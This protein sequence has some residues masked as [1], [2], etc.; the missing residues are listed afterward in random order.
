MDAFAFLSLVIATAAILAWINHRFVGLP[1]TIGV[2]LVALLMSLGL[3]AGDLLGLGLTAP[4]EDLLERFDFG[5]SLLEIML[6]FLLFAGSLHVDL[7]LLRGQRWVIGLLATAGVVATTGLAGLAL[8]AVSNT[9][10]LGLSTLHCLVFGSLIAP[11]DPIAVL[12]ILKSA[13]APASLEAKITG[14]SLFIDG[15]GVVVFGVLA[16]LLGGHGDHAADAGS[17]ALLFLQEVGGAAVLGLGG[18]WLCYRLLASVD[19][20]TVEVLLTLALCMGLYALALAVHA[21]GPLT[22]VLAGLLIGNSGRAHAMSDASRERLDT[23]WEIVDGVLNVVL[24]VLIGMEVLLLSWDGAALAAGLVA[25]P[26]VLA[27]R[28]LSVGATVTALRRRRTF[29]P[30]AVK[31]MTWGGLR[32]GISIALALSLA[33]GAA[34][35]TLLMVTYVVVVF[36]ILVQGLTVGRLVALIPDDARQELPWAH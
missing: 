5:G 20:H 2:M 3:L 14:E 9:L 32:G 18:G 22:A 28:F 24:F 1:T 27:A 36:S 15:I 12:G 21:S 8:L 33:P 17:V 34:R 23:F 25:I 7:E 35:D 13:G 4:I 6:A 19:D 29:T 10:D 26:L 16:G 30:H 11:T 31:I